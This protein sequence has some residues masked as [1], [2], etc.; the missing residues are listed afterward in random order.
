M[1]ALTPASHAMNIMTLRYP[2]VVCAACLLAGCV[3]VHDTRT[4]EQQKSD[5][6]AATDALVGTYEVVDS[7]RN[8]RH[9]TS[10]VVRKSAGAYG[11]DVTM[12]DASSGSAALRAGRKC[13]GYVV[14]G[15]S[16]ASVM[17]D[18]PAYGINYYS[19]GSVTDLDRTVRDGGV[20]KGFADMQI[21]IGDLLLEYS[22]EMSGRSHYLVLA[23]KAAP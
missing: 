8:D 13:R 16:Y 23:K 14:R 21:P 6:H 12:M 5:L 3:S 19:L 2:T 4:A 15:R 9:F 1:N 10:V 11:P 20:I 18:A 7:R 17:C 22:E